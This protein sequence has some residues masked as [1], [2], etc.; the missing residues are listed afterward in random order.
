MADS[1]RERRLRNDFAAIQ[2]L[3]SESTIL[4]FVAIGALPESY[5]LIFR[6]LGV[7]KPE[8]HPDVLT[9]DEHQ[10]V[11]RLSA[12]YPR[13]MPELFW[14]T[15]IF[16]PNIS[17]SGVV[18]LGGY[19]TYWV[20]SVTLDELC[21]MLWDMIRYKNFD[22]ESPYNRQAALWAKQYATARFPIDPRPIRNKI[23]TASAF[24]AGVSTAPPKAPAGLRDVTST[25]NRLFPSRQTQ[26]PFRTSHTDTPS[27]G[28]PSPHIS[29]DSAERYV[30]NSGYGN[31]SNGSVS[32]G[33]GSSSAGN[34][35][36]HSDPMARAA[37]MLSPVEA[38]I[39]LAEVIDSSPSMPNS[40][41][42]SSPVVMRPPTGDI[43]FIE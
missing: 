1:P 29:R 36:S 40:P 7:W 33:N 22:P 20:P 12:G 27:A 31:G 4:D 41:L 24:P 3:Q 16:H 28:P 18:C 2:K 15:P 32:N 8:H 17:S 14:K 37:A 43:L 21:T 6:G 26:S 34:G 10:V 5:T 13:M 9:R 25:L 30:A 19:G 23:A 38:E 35:A 39:V 11:V 42:A